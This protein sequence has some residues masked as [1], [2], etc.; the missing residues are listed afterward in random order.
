MF[1]SEC[2][3]HAHGSTRRR[4]DGAARGA[5][6][7]NQRKER[8]YKLRI[9][10]LICGKRRKGT[11]SQDRTAWKF[12]RRSDRRRCPSLTVVSVPQLCTVE[13][14]GQENAISRPAQ[15]QRA[16]SIRDVTR[17]RRLV[18]DYP[19]IVRDWER[20]HM[21]MTII[22]LRLKRSLPDDG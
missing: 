1:R 12:G 5:R 15:Q 10:K 20:L 22:G 19:P 14:L 18:A 4:T 13:Q 17:N 6:V 11:S 9:G 8:D 3:G 21:K 2:C 16:S 7:P